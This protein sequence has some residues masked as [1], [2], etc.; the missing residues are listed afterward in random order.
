M[1]VELGDYIG[2]E[3]A[4]EGTLYSLELW[5]ME[6]TALLDTCK[7]DLFSKGCDLRPKQWNVVI[8][9]EYACCFLSRTSFLL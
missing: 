9:I 8:A 2:G 7:G 6:I 5:R 3:I 1:I 4:V